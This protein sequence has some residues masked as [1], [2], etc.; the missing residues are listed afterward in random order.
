MHSLNLDVF[1][2]MVLDIHHLTSVVWLQGD[3]VS[4]S[5]YKLEL[6]LSCFW[7]VE[8]IRIVCI[9]S[10][11]L[12][13][14]CDLYHYKLKR[15]EKEINKNHPLLWIYRSLK[16]FNHRLCDDIVFTSSIWF[17]YCF[18]C[19]SWIQESNLLKQGALLQN[20]KIAGLI[21]VFITVNRREYG[22]YI[23]S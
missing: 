13:N 2:H 19:S 7:W 11:C 4:W 16:L 12:I 17:F 3:P 10:L 14:S 18:W 15:K 5:R 20:P 23:W 22:F 1:R 9:L 8:T 6:N 21:L